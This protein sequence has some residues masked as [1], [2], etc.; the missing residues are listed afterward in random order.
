MVPEQR[1]ADARA[2]PQPN[3]DT[4]ADA[5]LGASTTSVNPMAGHAGH[6]QGQLRTEVAA[7]LTIGGQ[8]PVDAKGRLLHEG[9]MAAQLALALANLTA[10]VLD[11]GMALTDIAHL[12]IHTTD[13][14][15]LLDVQFV[16]SER[17]AEQGATPPI[18]IV[19]VSRLALPGME[20]E[21]DGLAVRTKRPTEGNPR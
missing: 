2:M 3:V 18:S 16:V 1:H 6:D 14:A 4:T 5:F 20:L 10:V 15:S 17:L 13:I 19:E 9:D 7:I 12:R 8:R 21:I 11:S